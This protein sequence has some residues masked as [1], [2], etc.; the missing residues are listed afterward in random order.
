MLM[1]ILGASRHLKNKIN[2]LLTF[3]ICLVLIFVCSISELYIFKAILQISFSTC[4]FEIA[5]K[6][7]SK[8]SLLRGLIP[9]S[10][11]CSVQIFLNETHGQI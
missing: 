4:F 8:Q 11:N 7:K 5:I 3:G 1:M 9:S 10:T 2:Y 6:L